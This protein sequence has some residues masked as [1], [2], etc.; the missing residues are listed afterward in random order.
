MIQI[1]IT[2]QRLHYNAKQI[3]QNP[4]IVIKEK[5]LYQKKTIKKYILNTNIKWPAISSDLNVIENLKNVK[6]IME[7]DPTRR[8]I[9][10][11]R[12]LLKTRQT[13]I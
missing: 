8:P 12:T 7:L 9:K 11:D 3:H 5:N 10:T 4:R 1:K 6:V 13:I 2:T